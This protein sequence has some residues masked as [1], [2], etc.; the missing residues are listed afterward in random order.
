MRA[1]HP[2]FLKH[3]A[4]D[5][6]WVDTRS[7]PALGLGVGAWP[8][9]EFVLADRVGLVLLTDGLFEGLCGDG[10]RRLGEEGLLRVAVSEAA[11]PD[12]EFIEALIA[13]VEH[14]A[15]AQGGLDDDVAVI[16]VQLT[17]REFG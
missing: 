4:T 1:G 13:G 12:L 17:P 15:R 16:R 11:R 8:E 7:G 14:L 6:S 3:T 5:V 10:N 2:G 9:D